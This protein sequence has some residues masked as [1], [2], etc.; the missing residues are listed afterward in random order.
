[1]RAATRSLIRKRQFAHLPVELRNTIVF[2]P[3]DRLNHF[4]FSVGEDGSEMNRPELVFGIRD[5][6]KKWSDRDLNPTRYQRFAGTRS[7]LRKSCGIRLLG[8]PSFAEQVIILSR[9]VAFQAIKCVIR[10]LNG[11]N[12]NLLFD[13]GDVLRGLY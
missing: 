5:I 7:L 2:P 8:A 6:G 11:G 3:P 1:M 9:V 4:A 10:R 13:Y 12:T